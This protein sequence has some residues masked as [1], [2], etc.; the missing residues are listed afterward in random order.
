MKSKMRYLKSS[1]V[2]AAAWKNKTGSGL[3]A[4]GDESS[5]SA[6]VNKICPNFDLL[7]VIFGQRKNVNHGVIFESTDSIEV[8]TDSPCADSSLN[9]TIDSYDLCAL[10][11]EDLVDPILPI[12]SDCSA[13]AAGTST[14]Q[15][16]LDFR[17]STKKPKRKGEAPFNK[18]IFIQEKRLELEVK[19]IELEKEKENNEIELKRIELNNQLEMKRIETES[20]KETKLEIE[21]LKLASEERIKMFELELKLKSK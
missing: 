7:E 17:S 16:S 21:K 20:E 15:S 14:P 5:V 9:D 1:Y 18:L 6:H 3:L 2:A 8:L 11:C 19:K 4:N 13:A 10:D 12:S